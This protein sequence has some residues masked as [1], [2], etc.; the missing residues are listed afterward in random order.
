MP[1]PNENPLVTELPGDMSGLGTTAPFDPASPLPTQPSFHVRP[2]P[3]W[4]GWDVI[5]VLLVTAI[6]VFGFSIAALFIAR[7]TSQY[8]NTPIAELA[9]NARVV[10][11]AQ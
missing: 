6:V 4:S 1:D 3:A 7:A 11:G 9:T 2:F 8:R 5:A 10:I